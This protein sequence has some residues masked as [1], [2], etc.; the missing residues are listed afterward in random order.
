MTSGKRPASPILF[1]TI[2]STM[3]DS[4]QEFL[5]HRDVFVLSAA[6]SSCPSKTLSIILTLAGARPLDRLRQGADQR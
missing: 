6:L 1:Y 2:V 3:R 5:N 4:I